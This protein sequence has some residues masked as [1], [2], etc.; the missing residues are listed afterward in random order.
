MENLDKNLEE[1]QGKIRYYF[2]EAI[3]QNYPGSGDV[4]A[5]VLLTSLLNG[6]D[7]FESSKIAVDFTYFSVKRTFE[8]KT[9]PRFGLNFEEEIP[10]LIS[11]LHLY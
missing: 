2:N 11:A 9:D 7:L 1:F 4:F 10:N 6:F 3:K 5:S 8:N